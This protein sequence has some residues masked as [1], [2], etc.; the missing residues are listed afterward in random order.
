M[1][2][3]A[4]RYGVSK[5]SLQRH[6]Q[7]CLPSILSEYEEIEYRQA[8]EGVYEIL[9]EHY[10]QPIRKPRPRSIITKKVVCN[11]GRKAQKTPK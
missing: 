6:I 2:D 4:E 8:L 3:T 7:S 10:S 5:S 1:R 11:W 9:L